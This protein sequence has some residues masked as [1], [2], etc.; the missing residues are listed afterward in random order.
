LRAHR[1]GRRFFA[2]FITCLLRTAPRPAAKGANSTRRQGIPPCR[3]AV[4]SALPCALP[5]SRSG[6]A[7]RKRPATRLR[8]QKLPLAETL[9]LG[10]CYACRFS[11]GQR[12]PTELAAGAG[13]AATAPLPRCRWRHVWADDAATETARACSLPCLYSLAAVSRCE[14]RRGYCGE[15]RLRSRGGSPGFA[16]LAVGT[17]THMVSAASLG[18]FNRTESIRG[19]ADACTAPPGLTAGDNAAIHRFQPSGLWRSNVLSMP[20]FHWHVRSARL[21]AAGWMGLL[22]AA[23]ALCISAC[24]GHRNAI[25]AYYIVR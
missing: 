13:V 12:Q 2:L 19:F 24:G 9:W 11:Y 7:R 23:W 6:I 17:A 5:T 1:G 8:I 20:A 21:G 25:P 22:P 15:E 4:P 3:G 18:V 16:G 14:T 10:R